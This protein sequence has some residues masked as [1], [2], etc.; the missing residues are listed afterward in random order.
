[1]KIVLITLTSMMFAVSS[2]AIEIP[3]LEKKSG[4]TNCHA[5][6]H[7]VIGPSWQDVALKYRDKTTYE[8]AGKKYPLEDYS[9]PLRQDNNASSLRG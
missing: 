9:G 3:E 8:Y 6:D 5:I 1:M 7:T 2:M 4:C